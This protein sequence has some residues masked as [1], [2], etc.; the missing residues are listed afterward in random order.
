MSKTFQNFL[1]VAV[2]AIGGYYLYENWGSIS[3][4]LNNAMNNNTLGSGSTTT[5]NP[6]N[7][8]GNPQGNTNPT[9]V[10]DNDSTNSTNDGNTDSDGSDGLGDAS[11]YDSGGDD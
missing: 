2:L 5:S 8:F 3:S 6:Q 7:P 1:I 10:N 9:N 11:D 4:Q